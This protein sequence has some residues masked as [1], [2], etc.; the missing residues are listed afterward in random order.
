MLAPVQGPYFVVHLYAGRRRDQDF[1]AHMQNLLDAS[2]EPWI[3]SVYVLSIDT[4]IDEDSMDVQSERLWLFL[5]DAARQ[6]RIL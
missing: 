4:A 5:I 3:S 2:S 1:H 6:G